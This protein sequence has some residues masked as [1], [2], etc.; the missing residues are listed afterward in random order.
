MV[1]VPVRSALPVFSWTET[2]TVDPSVVMVIHPLAA[3]ETVAVQEV[4]F[5]VTVPCWLPL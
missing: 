4:W 1:T 5:V 3:S 2:V